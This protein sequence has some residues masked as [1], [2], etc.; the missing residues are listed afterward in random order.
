MPPRH[1]TLLDIPQFQPVQRQHVLFLALLFVLVPRNALRRQ[2]EPIISGT[3]LHYAQ[4]VDA[5]VTLANDLVAEGTAGSFSCRAFALTLG[6]KKI[7]MII[8]SLQR[9]GISFEITGATQK[10]QFEISLKIVVTI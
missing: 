5:H 1:K 3:A 10:I 7:K 8:N 9:L 6:A 2:N 4:I